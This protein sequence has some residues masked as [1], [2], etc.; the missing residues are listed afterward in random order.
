MLSNLAER[1]FNNEEKKKLMYELGFLFL[2]LFNK[3]CINFFT[4]KTYNKVISFVNSNS[5][6]NFDYLNDHIVGMKSKREITRLYTNFLIFP[7]NSLLNNRLE[8]F[9]SE[10]AEYIEELIPMSHLDGDIVVLI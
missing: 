8:R 5:I 9:K 2:N 10:E 3:S 1:K 6:K 4:S 7:N